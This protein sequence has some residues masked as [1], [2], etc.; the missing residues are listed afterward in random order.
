MNT[1]QITQ[2][3]IKGDAFSQLV[4][5]TYAGQDFTGIS[6][7]ATLLQGTTVLSSV[8]PTATATAGTTGSASVVLSMTGTQTTTLG[9]GNYTIR[10]RI[11]LSG[12]GPYTILALNFTIA[13]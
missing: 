7:T 3:T 12:W 11:S 10:L 13:N 6:A 8:T 2:A 9:A 1:V 4:N 5:I